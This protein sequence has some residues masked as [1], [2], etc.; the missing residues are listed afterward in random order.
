MNCKYIYILLRE[1]KNKNS[2]LLLPLKCNARTLRA[3][4]R[5]HS[6]DYRSFF[7]KNNFRHTIFLSFTNRSRRDRVNEK[8]E[9]HGSNFFSK[10]G[11]MFLSNWSY[12]SDADRSMPDIVQ[13]YIPFDWKSSSECRSVKE[14]N[15][16]ALSI[17]DSKNY[18]PSERKRNK[19][20]PH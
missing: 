19:S 9:L 3:F 14:I 10:L 5:H 13:K 17:V 7:V 1:G 16:R 8:I 12:C 6:N 20:T 18:S 4:L 2:P 11:R 15:R